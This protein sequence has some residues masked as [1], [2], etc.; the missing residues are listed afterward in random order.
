MP[1]EM[2]PR[3]VFN[4][5]NQTLR[6][7]ADDEMSDSSSLDEDE[8]I[9]PTQEMG[10]YIAMARAGTYV[11]LRNLREEVRDSKEYQDETFDIIESNVNNLYKHLKRIQRGTEGTLRARDAYVKQV[12]EKNTR[13]FVQLR[14]TAGE[15]QFSCQEQDD[16][17]DARM[18]VIEENIETATN[19]ID[20]LKSQ[21]SKN[22]EDLEASQRQLSMTREAVN[23]KE[24]D[25]VR[26]E[27]QIE[28]RV[29]VSTFNQTV[30]ALNTRISKLEEGFE[31][32]ALGSRNTVVE[33]TSVIHE[34]DIPN[35]PTTLAWTIFAAGYALFERWISKEKTPGQKLVE[36]LA[37]A[38]KDGKIVD[39]ERI[40]E[41]RTLLGLSK[42]D[43][44]VPLLKQYLDASPET[45]DN[46]WHWA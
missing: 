37:L 2:P 46:F 15:L 5:S 6:I 16:L 4:T 21:V 22:T 42:N 28:E 3:F 25:V 41:L 17:N 19:N 26:L 23:D 35:K 1:S 44:I 39:V 18:G 24:N 31:L 11:A 36:F 43:D 45:H 32:L 27:S 9:I 38:E 40:G 20:A 33:R 30:S 13:A 7:P 10:N 12:V 14:E 8:E 34:H 29:L